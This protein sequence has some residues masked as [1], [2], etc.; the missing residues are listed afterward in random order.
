MYV[1][2]LGNPSAE[3]MSGTRVEVSIMKND[4]AQTAQQ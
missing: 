2:G 4:L 1:L 3:R